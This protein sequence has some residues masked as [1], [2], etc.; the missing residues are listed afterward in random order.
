MIH[1]RFT[2]YLPISFDSTMPEIRAAPRQ[3]HRCFV[4]FLEAI[5]LRIAEFS[6]R[7][8]V[9]SVFQSLALV[10]HPQH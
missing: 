7:S 3:G 5:T 10:P 6:E 1:R 8:A 9:W 2:Y 4:F